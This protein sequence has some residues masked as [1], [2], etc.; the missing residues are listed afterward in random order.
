MEIPLYQDVF[1]L[2]IEDGKGSQLTYFDIMPPKLAESPGKYTIHDVLLHLPSLETLVLPLYSFGELPGFPE[3]AFPQL[4]HFKLREYPT[5]S[6]EEEVTSHVA[7]LT[8]GDNAGL[9]RKLEKF[10]VIYDWESD[11]GVLGESDAA[12]FARW[13]FGTRRT[14][15]AGLGGSGSSFWA[16][17]FDGVRA[18]W[19]GGKGWVPVLC[20]AL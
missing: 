15:L 17:G 1:S 14:G 16:E 6:T 9:L 4:R 10:T 5:L 13:W 7:Q 11:K 3:D 8:E 19:I 20:L 2:L 18:R 12:R